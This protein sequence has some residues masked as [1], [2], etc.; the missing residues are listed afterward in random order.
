M[1]TSR[2]RYDLVDVP[3]LDHFLHITGYDFS[4][5]FELQKFLKSYASMGFQATELSN[6]IEIWKT[7]QREHAV[8]FLACTSN[9]VSSGNR[10]IIRYLIE[11]KIVHA[12]ITTAGGIEEDIIKTIKP[13][14]L[15]SFKAD[16]KYLFEKGINRIGNIFVTNDR[17]TYFE[18]WFEPLLDE[19][20][21]EHKKDDKAIAASDLIRLMGKKA[22]SKES[23]L[24]WA[25]KNGTPVFCPAPMDG[26]IGDII[27]FHRQNH[28]EFQV[29]VAEDISKIVSLCINAEKT[30]VIILGGGVAKHFTLNAQI[31]REGAD[32]AIFLNTALEYDGS[33]SGASPDEA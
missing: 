19:I 29:D 22:A 25:Y 28:P 27:Y 12:L 9:M 16:G 17:Y 20:S 30:G 6:A 5:K 24:Y 15:G 2:G 10:E 23:I 33:D 11:K 13:F 18:K 7:M 31:F 3:N 1:K 21:K 14:V 4:K 26:S 32:Y 8:I